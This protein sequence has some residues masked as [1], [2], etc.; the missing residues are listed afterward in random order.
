MEYTRNKVIV[1][2]FGVPFLVGAVIIATVWYL[3]LFENSMCAAVGTLALAVFIWG[4]LTSVVARY[5]T[6][7]V[8]RRMH[9]AALREEASPEPPKE[10]P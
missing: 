2:V 1:I 5:F 6:T 7:S 10:E 8:A 4:V 9:K 3:G